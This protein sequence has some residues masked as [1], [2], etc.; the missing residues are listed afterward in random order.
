MP[1]RQQKPGAG[2]TL[3]ELLVVI[4]IIAILAAL[5]LPALANAK[6]KARRISCTNNLKQLGASLVMYAGDSNDY[7]PKAKFSGL[8][9]AQPWQ[10]YLLI[11]DPPGPGARGNPADFSNPINHGYFWT[12]KLIS[13]GQSFY[14]PSVKA[15]LL[16]ARY[17]TYTS[18]TVPWPMSPSNPN[19]SVQLRSSYNYYPQSAQLKT[20]NGIPVNPD[21]YE[22]ATKSIQLHAQHAVMVDLIH[23]TD[24]LTHLTGKG[25]PGLNTVWGD[26]HVTF[27]KAREAFDSSLWSGSGPGANTAQF[28]GVLGRLKP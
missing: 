15:E 3:I 19:T 17:D 14:C 16:M 13:A 21:L 7:L 9:G 20:V 1:K 26:T 24:T 4:A 5:L 12:T 6:E 11:D 8:G 18:P 2:F 23:T 25:S 22:P 27:S 10:S 28:I